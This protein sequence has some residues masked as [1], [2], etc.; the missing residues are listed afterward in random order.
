MW[1]DKI[2]WLLKELWKLLGIAVISD[3]TLFNLIFYKLRLNIKKIY[4]D[5]LAAN[6]ILLLKDQ[7]SDKSSIPV[8]KPT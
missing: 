5:L 4:P 1:C 3:I 8:W 6:P 2:P 7:T